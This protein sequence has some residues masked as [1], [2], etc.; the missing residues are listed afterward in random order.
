MPYAGGLSSEDE[1]TVSP[2]MYALKYLAYM[3]VIPRVMKQALHAGGAN[4]TENHIKEFGVHE[5]SHAH[6]TREAKQ[7]EHLQLCLSQH[8]KIYL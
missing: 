4:V 6:T 5:Q 2:S 7:E 1:T 8:Y 3:I